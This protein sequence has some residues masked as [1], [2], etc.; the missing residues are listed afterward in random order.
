[1]VTQESAWL[2]GR[3]LLVKELA[4]RVAAMRSGLERLNV[5]ASFKTGLL[6]FLER[7]L[8]HLREA[9]DALRHLP[10]SSSAG[11][12]Q[13]LDRMVSAVAGTLRHAEIDGD[14]GGGRDPKPEPKSRR[15]EPYPLPRRRVARDPVPAGERDER[16]GETQ[17]G[18]HPGE[19]N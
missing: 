18:G 5:S 11:L 9:L 6:V 3:E 4:D 10:H 16:D 12:R 7:R 14:E 13:T 2:N 17:A 1:M 15:G 19:K 8:E